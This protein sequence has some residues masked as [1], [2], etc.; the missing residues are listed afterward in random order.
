MCIESIALLE[1][2]DIGNHQQIVCD[3]LP[4]NDSLCNLSYLFSF[5]FIVA[6]S[7]QHV[8]NAFLV[9]NNLTTSSIPYQLFNLMDDQTLINLSRVNKLMRSQTTQFLREA[10]NLCH[11]IGRFF[12][13][14]KEYGE[15][16]DLQ[17]LHSLHLS[18]LPDHYNRLPQVS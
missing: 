16:Q 3:L 15:F 10:H 11:T 13:I 6:M 18:T 1:A 12:Q 8:V 4:T 7:L 2:V 14:P 9:L 5:S 17:V